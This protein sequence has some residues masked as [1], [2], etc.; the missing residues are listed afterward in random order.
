MLTHSE[1]VANSQPSVICT[2][3]KSSLLALRSVTGMTHPIVV[4]IRRLL[5]SMKRFEIKF[6]W[7]PGHAGIQGNETADL[8]AKESLTHP[9]RNNISCPS[10]DVFNYIHSHFLQYLQRTWEENHHFHSFYIKPTLQHWPSAHQDTRLKEVLLARL[11]LGHTR[12]THSF[13]LEKT[14]P[15]LCH[16]CHTRY[17]ISHFLLHCP[18]YATHRIPLIRY[19]DAN[20][21]PLTLPIL[22]G[23][24]Y[25][26]LLDLLF[27]FLR[28]TRLE[29]F[30]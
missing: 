14:D 19:A 11:R 7:I 26:D 12:I 17:N 1:C 24:L 29:I 25:P 23:D 20:R 21:L 16:R 4:Q 15:P 22:L 28:K 30:I 18:L 5:S 6:L 10:S 8:C 13:I 9:D 3:S 27:D 2:D